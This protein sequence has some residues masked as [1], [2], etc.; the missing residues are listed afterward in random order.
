MQLESVSTENIERVE[1]IHEPVLAEDIK[2]KKVLFPV[3]FSDVSKKIAPYVREV[4]M[5]LDAEVQLLFVAPIFGHVTSIYLLHPYI[6]NFE[7]KIEEEAVRK[8]E[9]FVEGSFRGDP[10]EARIVF[11][12]PAEEILT[13]A[14]WEKIDLIIMG[15]HERNGAEHGIFGSVAERVKNESRLP[16]LTIDSY[17]EW[18]EEHSVLESLAMQDMAIAS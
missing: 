6:R 9:E 12:D 11:G 17:E 14:K 2:V 3:D 1:H 13:Y 15:T 4:A 5:H 8:L 18:D 7:A 10:C 16:V